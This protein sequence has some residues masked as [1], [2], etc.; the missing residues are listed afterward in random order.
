M[1]P[2]STHARVHLRPCLR[3]DR[4]LVSGGGEGEAGGGRR[5]RFLC[6]WTIIP[7]FCLTSKRE[8]GGGGGGRVRSVCVGI[9]RC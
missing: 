6:V 3:A 5:V 4:S 8:R 2:F 9:G 1:N 7:L